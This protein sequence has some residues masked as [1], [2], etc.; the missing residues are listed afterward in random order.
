MLNSLLGYNIYNFYLT[1]S[2]V[3]SDAP[4][5]TIRKKISSAVDSNT[6]TSF[7]H[8]KRVRNDVISYANDVYENVTTFKN[9]VRDLLSD[10]DN[11]T[12]EYKQG[13]ADHDLMERDIKRFIERFNAVRD[14][15]VEHGRSPSLS[16]FSEGLTERIEQDYHILKKVGIIAEEN[17]VL[18][19]HPELAI[20]LSNGFL[21]HFVNN[22]TEAFRD[23]YNQ[24]IDLLRLPMVNHLNFNDY[25]YNYSYRF[26]KLVT[27]GYAL[28]E[29]GMILD[30]AV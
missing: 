17:G 16:S 20:D 23:M 9:S 12:D 14:Y 5:R 26:G 27:D 2:I 15:I 13:E 7:S 11:M 6:K 10:A 25:A 1:R 18:T 29:S 19:F 8:N 24:S 21:S 3:R 22:E 28:I 4:I 30:S